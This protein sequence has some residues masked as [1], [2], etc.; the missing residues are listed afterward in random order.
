MRTPL[1]LAR[2]PHLFNFRDS[3]RRVQT[4]RAGIRTIHDRVAAIKAE[5][6]L[7]IIET[8]ACRLITAINQPAIGL[9][10][11]SWA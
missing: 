2:H 1:Y 5:R 9:Q 7:K 3:L 6:I 4:L 11:S 8:L 10:Q